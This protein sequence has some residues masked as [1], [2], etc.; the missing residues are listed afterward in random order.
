MSSYW[1]YEV[2]FVEK[3]KVDCFVQILYMFHCYRRSVV[4]LHLFLST[5]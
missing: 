1:I 5:F 4:V 3:I 2:G